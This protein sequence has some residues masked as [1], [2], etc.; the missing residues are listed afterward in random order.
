[1]HGKMQFLMK[2]VRYDDSENLWL[3]TSQLDSANRQRNWLSITIVHDIIKCLHCEVVHVGTGK[4][5]WF[6]HVKHVC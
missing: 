2:W 4:Y 3:A 1:M 5:A 6:N